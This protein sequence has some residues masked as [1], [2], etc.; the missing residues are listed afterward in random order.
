MTTAEEAYR[1]LAPAVLGYLRAQRAPEPEDVLGEV[2]LQVARDLPRFRGDDD[3]F[4][5]WVFSI[6]H[7][8]LLDARRRVSRRPQ[9]S[10][11]E[12]PEAAVPPPEDAFDPDLVDA[13]DD[14][15]PDQREVVILR[16]VA[17]LP[18][19][20]VARI[21]G[22]R[23]GAV[24]AMQHRALETLARVLAADQAETIRLPPVSS[25][26]DTALT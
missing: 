26:G 4:R 5:R 18:L 2:F 12:V 14:L 11:R 6:A 22:R 3:A 16:F 21:T 1:T 10:D 13:L 25:K 8:R 20:D 24:K 15:T 7:N 23:V 17:D 9:L 19:A